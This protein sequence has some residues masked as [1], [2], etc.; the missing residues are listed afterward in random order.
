MIRD[1]RK[2]IDLK[3]NFFIVLIPFRD[4]IPSNKNLTKAI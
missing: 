2:A 4:F 3:L 1:I